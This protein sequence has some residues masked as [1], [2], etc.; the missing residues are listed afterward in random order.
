MDLVVEVV[1]AA[2]LRQSVASL[3]LDATISIV[4]FAGGEAKG[5]D[6]PNLLD[7]WLKH[8]TARGISVG[9]R[10]LMEAMCR[11]VAANVDKL[12]PVVDARV[13]KLDQ[14]KEAYEYLQAGKNMGK[15]CIDAS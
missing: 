4:G 12:R 6:V 15:V 13:F 9:N 3:R 8:Y 11:A 10:L 5:A 1:G 2:T 14:A 7:P